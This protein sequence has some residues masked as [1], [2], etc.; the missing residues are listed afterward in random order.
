[1]TPTHQTRAANRE[2]TFAF[3]PAPAIGQIS[4]REGPAQGEKEIDEEFE[5]LRT[6]L[7]AATRKLFIE[8]GS[9]SLTS[10]VGSRRRSPLRQKPAKP[11]A[12]F[13]F[14]S[15]GRGVRELHA[16]GG[17]STVTPARTRGAASWNGMIWLGL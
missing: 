5:R 13:G 3:R 14:P 4:D 2:A 6:E 11:A 17:P 12:P 16:G 8:R 15:P 10:Q 1:L 9:S 7:E